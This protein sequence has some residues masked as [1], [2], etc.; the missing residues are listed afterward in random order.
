MK[1]LVLVLVFGAVSL[2]T[3]QGQEHFNFDDFQQMEFE[4]KYVNTRQEKKK[5]IESLLLP[6]QLL[7]ALHTTANNGEIEMDMDKLADIMRELRPDL[8]LL[9][10]FIKS[11]IDEIYG[12]FED[13]EDRSKVRDTLIA[14]GEMFDFSVEGL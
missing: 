12:L 4:W 11:H 2:L 9:F 5:S 3:I 13:K 14:M 7:Y 10:G 8:V 6:I 1:K